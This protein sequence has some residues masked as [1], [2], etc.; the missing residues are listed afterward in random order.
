MK[1]NN[2]LIKAVFLLFLWFLT[3][4]CAQAILTVN[5][6]ESVALEQIQ[7]FWSGDQSGANQ[8]SRIINA[9]PAISFSFIDTGPDSAT[10]AK[11]GTVPPTTQ[12]IFGSDDSAPASAN[13]SIRVWNG[14]SGASGGRYTSL[15]SFGNPALAP[16]TQNISAFN[17]QFIRDIPGQGIINRADEIASLTLPST[18][19]TRLKLFSQQAPR[20]DTLTVERSRCIWE[21]LYTPSGGSE[22]TLTITETGT[23]LELLPS[24]ANNFN[25]GDRY[26]IRVR[27]VNLW[28]T[29]GPWS[30][31]YNHAITGAGPQ[32]VTINLETRVGGTPAGPGINSFAMPFGGPW[33]DGRGT[34][35]VNALDLVR[36]INTAAGSSVVSSFGRWNKDTQQVA[37]VMIPGNT[38][39]AAIQDRLDDIPISR[40][41]GYQVYVTGRAP[42]VI[43]NTP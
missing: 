15:S 9:D 6:P 5:L 32:S 14:A 24:P 38:L 21:V 43:K 42:L 18:R 20:G 35:I 23:D 25:P 40:S 37:G 17:Y 4:D 13:I 39:T 11:A 41:E 36:A 1:L 2:Y 7:Y 19:T 22:S 10:L 30:D 26:S 29:P 27:Y 8:T 33:Y 31:V 3:A 16:V 28:E 34:P 12:L